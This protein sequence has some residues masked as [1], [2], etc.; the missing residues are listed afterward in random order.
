MSSQNDGS[1]VGN[2][3]VDSV[4]SAVADKVRSNHEAVSSDAILEA[5]DRGG[6]G[7]VFYGAKPTTYWVK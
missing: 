3:L 7:A 2:F 4:V 6:T 5:I 1:Y